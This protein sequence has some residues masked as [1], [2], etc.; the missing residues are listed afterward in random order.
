MAKKG[1]KK[2]NNKAW[3]IVLSIVAALLTYSIVLYLWQR[4]HQETEFA[5]YPAFNIEL[6]VGYIIHGIDVS[7]H[8]GSVQWASVKS[9]RVNNVSIGFA[10]IKAT[11]GLGSVDKQFRRNWL[12]VKEANMPRGAYHYFIATKS[13]RAQALNFINTVKLDSGDMPPVV[14]I[15]KLYKASPVAMRKELKAWLQ[16]VEA[17]Y[18][19][20][21]VIYTFVD[22]YDTYLGGEFDKYPLWIAH[23]YKKEKPR[24]GRNW[25]FWQHNDLGHVD[26]ISAETD[27]DVFK[28]DSAAF[29]Q[30]LL[31]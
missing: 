25:L 26:G 27:F 23:Y 21:P 20:K 10:F 6:P 17:Y 5:R 19:V 18:K 12:K 29:K 11:E 31:K 24:I 14:D 2:R 16:V 28:S 3:L 15:E 7:R 13:G 9:M 1:T 22:F 4:R 30:L 8:Q